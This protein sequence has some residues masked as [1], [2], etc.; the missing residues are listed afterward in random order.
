MAAEPLSFTRARINS[1]PTPETGEQWYFDDHKDY[2]RKLRLRLS[3][4]GA[5][6]WYFYSKVRGKPKKIAIGACADISVSDARKAAAR[7]GGEVAAGRDPQVEKQQRRAESNREKK[8]LSDALEQ[9]LKNGSI[10]VSQRS[11]SGEISHIYL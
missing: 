2:R 4:T 8:R 5:R 11:K 10:R 9:L 1:L 3:A 6:S 7:L